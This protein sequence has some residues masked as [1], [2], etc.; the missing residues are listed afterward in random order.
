MLLLA[1]MS[2]SGLGK[3]SS[4]ISP[5]TFSMAFVFL[6]ESSSLS[7]ILR[8]YLLIKRQIKRQKIV[9]HSSWELWLY[10]FFKLMFVN[11]LSSDLSHIPDSHS[12]HI[13]ACWA[14]FPLCFL[15]TVLSFPIINTHTFFKISISLLNTFSCC[16]FIHTVDFLSVF[17][18]CAACFCL[19]TLCLFVSLSWSWIILASFL[20]FIWHFPFFCLWIQ[21]LRAGNLFIGHAKSFIV[22]VSRST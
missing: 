3:L 17:C 14:C 13:R 16:L 2:F 8:L 6:P 9:Q 21:P 11:I 5:K 12:M 1:C 10:Y 22:S 4:V 7:I 20:N 18:F 19:Q 15:F